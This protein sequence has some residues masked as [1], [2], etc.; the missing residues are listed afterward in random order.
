MNRLCRAVCCVWIA[1][2]LDACT[3]DAPPLSKSSAQ[4]AAPGPFTAA[5]VEAGRSAYAANCA[6]CHGKSLEGGSAGGGRAIDA[7]TGQRFLRSWSYT[8]SGH[9]YEYVYYTMPRG[10]E[11]SLPAPTYAAIV[12]FIFASNGARPGGQPYSASTDVPI[13]SF[14][15]TAN[16]DASPQSEP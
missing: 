16:T 4:V 8:T 7:L 11:K 10:R 3:V 14:V 1:A 12:A 5:Q 13:S 9:F 6:G 15:N 2:A